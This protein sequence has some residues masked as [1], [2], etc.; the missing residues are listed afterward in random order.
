MNEEFLHYIWKYRLLDPELLTVSGDRLIIIHPGEHNRDGG[1]DFFNARLKIGGTTWAGNVEIHLQASGWYK[2]KHHEDS[3]YDN[4]ILHAVYDN[5]VEVKRLSEE[6]IPTLVMKGH[7][8][9]YI[10]ERYRY[11]QENSQWVPCQ[12]LIPDTDPFILVQWLPALVVERLEKKTLVMKQ[13]LEAGKFD[14][15]EIFYQNLASSFGFRINAQPF[16]LLARSL[17]W[18]LLQKHR[19][20]LFQV[21]ALLFGQAGLLGEGFYR[22]LSPL[23]ATGI[24]VPE[25]EIWSSRNFRLTLEISQ[26]ETFKLSYPSHCP[27]C[28]PYSFCPR[29]LP[30]RAGKQR[31]QIVD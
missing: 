15:E 17:S 20:S 3:S 31:S 29:S 28:R 26:V 23:I 5:D 24:Q 16:E 4:I 21:E 18:K 9:G 2:H 11:F 8:P 19:T 30:V 25:G 10:F 1:P 12:A 27:V 6:K 22:G 14:W 13:S 7:F